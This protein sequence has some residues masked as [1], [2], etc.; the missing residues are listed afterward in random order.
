LG[1]ENNVEVLGHPVHPRIGANTEVE[2]NKTINSYGKHMFRIS[3]ISK[4]SNICINNCSANN[5]YYT[6]P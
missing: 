3:K 6:V 1:V 2:V 5:T 4:I